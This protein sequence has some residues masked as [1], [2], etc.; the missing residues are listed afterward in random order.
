[1][2]SV[3]VIEDQETIRDNIATILE[4]E[5]YSVISAKDGSYGLRFVREK[6]PDLIV[7][8][9]M[10]PGIDGYGVLNAV[11]HNPVTAAIPFIFLT[12]RADKGDLRQ[13][14][15]LGADDY[16][17][18][19]FTRIELL[20]SVKT[21]LQ[22]HSTILK[23]S[24]SAQRQTAA[25]EAKLSSLQEYS[26]ESDRLL[27]M[28]S[29]EFS[30]LISNINLVVQILSDRPNPELLDRYLKV[31]KEESKRGIDLLQQHRVLPKLVDEENKAVIDTFNQLIG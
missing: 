28:F 31:L 29:E 2:T 30:G 27:E 3:L 7:C 6:Q 18:K 19:P 13:G 1:M 10:M 5:G 12:A 21:R 24:V 9:I 17:T 8:D 11:R 22:K 16:L 20:E 14:M 15:N 26:V 23:R 25:L 4:S